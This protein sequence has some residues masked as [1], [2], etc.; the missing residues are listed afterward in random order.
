MSNHIISQHSEQV[1]PL[2]E[3]GKKA[4]SDLKNYIEQTL[5]EE[6]SIT[7]KS[8]STLSVSYYG[9]PLLFRVEIY[10]KNDANSLVMPPVA[11][12][13]AYRMS[14]DVKPE[15]VSLTEC[16]FNSVGDVTLPVE[17][18]SS[19]IDHFAGSFLAQ[20]FNATMAKGMTL[21]P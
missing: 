6:F 21:R 18:K 11:K 8:E 16:S 17:P 3:K 7:G 14:D 15:W 9:F 12:V 20:V 1:K 10:S 13:V 19:N 5:A 2:V 4:I